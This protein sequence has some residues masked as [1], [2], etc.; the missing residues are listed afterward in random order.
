M[1]I[2]GEW[3]FFPWFGIAAAERFQGLQGQKRTTGLKTKRDSG[4][5]GGFAMAHELF[6][7]DVL[8]SLQNHVASPGSPP[9]LLFLSSQ[10]C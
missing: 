5:Q 3:L 10:K 7:S 2:S 1:A 6:I 9:E 8:L 4:S